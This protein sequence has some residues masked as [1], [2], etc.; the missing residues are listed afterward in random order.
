MRGGFER[1]NFSLEANCRRIHALGTDQQFE[2]LPHARCSCAAAV[3]H[4]NR[5][6][7]VV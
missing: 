4:F 6:A 3:A 2:Y 5:S 7:M 1:Y